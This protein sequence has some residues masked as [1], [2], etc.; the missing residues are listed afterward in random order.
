MTIPSALFFGVIVSFVIAVSVLAAMIIR[1]R[2]YGSKP[3]FSTPSGKAS[4]GVL[5]AFGQGMLPWE[6]ESVAKHLPTY[7][8][9]IAYHVGIFAAFAYLALLL[10]NR[11][12]STSVL[13]VVQ[14]LL[15]I[16]LVCGLGLL[17]KR[18]SKPYM[19]FISVADD[20][21]ANGLIDVL[22]VLALLTTVSANVA[23]PYVVSVIVVLLYIPI[24][25]I[26]HCAFF[27][28]T[29]M[30]FGQFFGRRGVLPHR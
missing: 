9:G 3:K 14:I 27:F 15:A 1:T 4:S 21:I 2:A 12:L 22:L 5:Y 8:A 26:R 6:K 16:G 23:I 30:T 17:V 25:K 11:S 7:F 18:M 29:R 19:R 10:W 28:Y 24:G 13:I 20:Y